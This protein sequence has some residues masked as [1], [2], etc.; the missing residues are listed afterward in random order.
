MTPSPLSR[1]IDLVRLDVVT[2]QRYYLSL[3]IGLLLAHLCCDFAIFYGP[4]FFGGNETAVY[5]NLFKFNNRTLSVGI[6]A[7]LVLFISSASAFRSL[8]TKQ[9]RAYWLTVPATNLQRF[10]VAA[11]DRLVIGIV[12]LAVTY[13][14]TDWLRMAIMASVVEDNVSSVAYTYRESSRLLHTLAA[15][16]K[17]LLIVSG[18]TNLC[19]NCA[20]F[21]LGGAWFRRRP[22]LKTLGCIIVLSLLCGKV[23]LTFLQSKVL[24]LNLEIYA[25]WHSV[26]S[27][28]IALNLVWTVAAVWLAFRIYSREPIVRRKMF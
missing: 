27:Y 23:L 24:N 22:I 9:G 11:L 6:M 19:A 8:R 12:S 26:Q 15:N 5:F 28:S 18:A 16:G 17:A 2:Q 3:I 21:L 20:T 13:V 1:W 25:S 14:L 7:T 10:T 4:V